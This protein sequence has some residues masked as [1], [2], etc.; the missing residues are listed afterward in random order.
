[1]NIYVH[2]VYIYIG[3]NMKQYEHIES[4]RYNRVMLYMICTL[5]AHV[6]S[7]VLLNIVIIGDHVVQTS[8]VLMLKCKVAVG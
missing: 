2:I 3:S 6:Y 7:N 1:M 5:L 4:S 8:H